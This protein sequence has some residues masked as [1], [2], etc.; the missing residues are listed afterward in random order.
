MI[1]DPQSQVRFETV[2]SRV[3]KLRRSRARQAVHRFA[4]VEIVFALCFLL[5]SCRPRPTTVGPS[6]EF[7]KVPPAMQGGREKVDTIS[8]RVTGARRGQQ[9]VVYARSGPWWVQPWPDRTLH[10]HSIGFKLEHRDP[11]GL[12]VCGVISRAGI[13]ALAHDG[14]ASCE[15]RT[16]RRYRRS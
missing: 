14:C 8:G 3:I 16:N 12:R 5:C 4:R 1:V 11:H 10:S 7:S 6:I 15:G 9:I 2:Q 13:P